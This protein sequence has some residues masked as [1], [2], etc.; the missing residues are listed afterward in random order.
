MVSTIKLCNMLQRFKDSYRWFIF[1]RNE[2]NVAATRYAIT[3][4]TSVLYTYCEVKKNQKKKNQGFFLFAVN[5]GL[6]ISKKKFLPILITI[7][8]P[9]ARCF[10]TQR[11]IIVC[12]Y[13][14]YEMGRREFSKLSFS[15]VIV[16]LIPQARNFFEANC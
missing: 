3:V 13:L 11:T 2:N 7:V 16:I 8:V 9:L 14:P 15:S 1:T 4:V 6:K 10:F 5:K 12:V